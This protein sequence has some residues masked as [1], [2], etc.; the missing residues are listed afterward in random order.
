MVFGFEP[1]RLRKTPRRP[2]R[3]AHNAHST[4]LA[5]R[6]SRM[7]FTSVRLPD[8]GTA[9]DNQHPAGQRPLQSVAL[10]GRQFLSRSAVGTRPTAFEKS[11]ADNSRRG[12]KHLDPRRNPFFGALQD[13]QE[14]Q[15]RP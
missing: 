5:R 11:I 12:G 3:R 2:A 7:A 13:R 4:F 9:G 15:V 1:G 14:N 10:A 6:M 8:T